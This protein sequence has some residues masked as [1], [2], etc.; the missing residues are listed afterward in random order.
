MISLGY[1]HEPCRCTE[2]HNQCDRIKSTVMK[3][4]LALVEECPDGISWL[5]L[6]MTHE[7]RGVTYNK[8]VENWLSGMA[9]LD[10]IHTLWRWRQTSGHRGSEAERTPIFEVSRMYSKDS[11]FSYRQTP[12]DLARL[13]ECSESLRTFCEIFPKNSLRGSSSPKQMIKAHDHLTEFWK[14][15]RKAWNIGQMEDGNSEVSKSDM[16]SLMSFDVSPE[17]L[18]TV[19]AMRL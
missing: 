17:Y 1:S 6:K 10:E 4:G 9:L 19:E 5:L 3:M 11:F 14:C 12:V 16:L 15:A 13:Q 18:D 7:L 2:F 8:D